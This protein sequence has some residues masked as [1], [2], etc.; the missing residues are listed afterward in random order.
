M[1]AVPL[2]CSDPG[3]AQ[4]KLQWWREEI[5]RAY[6]GE[7]QH[8][9]VRALTGVIRQHDLPAAPFLAM[10]DAAEAQVL[11][12]SP[13]NL[14]DLDRQGEQEQGAL[15]E[16]LARY[17]GM[18]S[19][20]PLER[21]RRQGAHCTQVYLIRDFGALLRRNY[22]PLPA[23]LRQAGDSTCDHQQ[24]LRHIAG[25]ARAGLA[26]SLPPGT[27]PAVAVRTAILAALLETL[28]RANFA[29]LDT[30]IGLSPLRK[31]WI[32]WRAARRHA[33]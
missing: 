10:I 2:V 28:G 29:V 1:R 9:L 31:L 33:F 16:L 3:V 24:A 23:D 30:R 26:Q 13:A 22:N 19:P 18:H 7:A 20:K 14:A 21:L 4:L 6:G 25:H 8:P 17:H 5:E 11:R 27:P 32:G 12:E 15:F